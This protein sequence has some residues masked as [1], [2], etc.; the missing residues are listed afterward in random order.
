MISKNISFYVL[1]ELLNNAMADSSNNVK[2][3]NTFE[4]AC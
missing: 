4:G 3:V 1:N 2:R